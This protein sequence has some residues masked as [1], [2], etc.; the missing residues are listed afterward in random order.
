M[1]IYTE[2]INNK[3]FN[4]AI[5]SN[6][7]KVSQEY[8]VLAVLR[9]LFPGEYEQMEH[10]DKPDLQDSINHIG[11]EVTA[12]VL[13][14]DI[15]ASR[16]LAEIDDNSSERQMESIEKISQC[17]YEYHNTDGIKSI[18]KGGGASDSDKECFCNAIIKKSKKADNYKKDYKRLGLAV[19]LF[20]TPLRDTEDH[21]IDWIKEI[22]SEIK[23]SF[24]MI[25]V[26][27]SR[28]CF[29]CDIKN[30]YMDKKCLENT[31]NQLLCK[32]ARMTAEGDLT[33]DSIEWK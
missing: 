3:I 25:F 5:S 28:F 31:D 19:I 14:D 11:I 29:I 12:A 2:R 9:Y 20:E 26:I 32:I 27:S 15:K 21:I 23:T 7:V 24:D 13:E 33:L 4:G 1:N 10:G 8:R 30:D 16:L 17:C 6:L 18:T 22:H